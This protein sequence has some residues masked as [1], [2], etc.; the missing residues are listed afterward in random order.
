MLID[1]PG[2]A[3]LGWQQ[4]REMRAGGIRFGAHSHSHRI[5]SRLSEDEQKE[6]IARSKSILEDRLGEPI[7]FFAY[8]NGQRPD[9]SLSTVRLVRMEGFRGACSTIWGTRNRVK[10]VFALKRVVVDHDDDLTSFSLKVMGAYDYLGI[11][12]EMK[13]WRSFVCRLGGWR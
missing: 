9:F 7:E 4:I 12:H 2:F 3:S 6:E 1:E 8:P 11:F 5:L 10:D 13:P